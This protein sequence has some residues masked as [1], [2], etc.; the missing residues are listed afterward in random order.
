M[1]AL[2]CVGDGSR[3]VAAGERGI[4]L[5][6]VDGGRSWTQSAVPVQVSLTTLHFAD[7]RHGWAAGHGGVVLRSDD[8]GASWRLQLDGV[9]AAALALEAAQAGGDAGAI[10]RARRLVDDGPDKPWFDIDVDAT[11]RGLVVG[12]YGLA[13]ATDDGGA[14]WRPF[15]GALP[16]PKG[17]HLYALRRAGARAWIAG[18]QGLV[19]RADGQAGAGG[20][21]PLDFPY[22]GSLFGLLR[23]ARGSLLAYGLRGNAWR[24]VDA[25]ASWQ[26]VEPATTAALS[27]AAV[28]GGD[29]LALLSQ[30]GEL[31]ASSDD[32]ATWRRQ[33]VGAAPGATAVLAA[34]PQAVVVAGLGGVRR[35]E[36]PSSAA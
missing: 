5:A 24:S 26:R 6:S 28:L 19:L 18:E 17:L 2:A 15:A 4:V 27:G 35:I 13:F 9:R 31:F 29:G 36:W 23:T 33:P 3:L 30:A 11:G 12:A 34:G 22:K 25:G 1:L 14:R 10:A 16:D 7:D 20:F 32:G 21:A 8:G